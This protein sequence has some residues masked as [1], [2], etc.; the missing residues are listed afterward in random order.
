MC[1]VEV[2]LGGGEDDFF[3]NS[4]NPGMAL[5]NWMAFLSLFRYMFIGGTNFAYWNGKKL[6]K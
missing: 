2:N 1:S 3:P 5:I 4:A 6:F